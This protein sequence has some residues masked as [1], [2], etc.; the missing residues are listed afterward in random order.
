L[1]SGITLVPALDITSR[2]TGFLVLE[3]ALS[4]V[5]SSVNHGGQLADGLKN[6]GYVTHLALRMIQAGEA[7]GNLEFM[8]QRVAD[9]Y[10]EQLER[11]LDRFMKLLEPVIILVMG[12]LVG[13][14]ALAIML[15]IF[16]MNKLI[17]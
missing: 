15:P 4:E 12:L 7:A 11:S 3:D 5:V 8:L 1:K 2:S 14:I 9:N 16:E 13:F 17:S 6:C 10:L